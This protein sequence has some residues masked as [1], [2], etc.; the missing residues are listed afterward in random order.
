KELVGKK[1]K[2]L[3]DYF[4]NGRE[5]GDNGNG[6]QV[7]SGDFVNTEEGTGIVHI[8]PAFGE[9]DMELGKKYGLPFIQHVDKNGRFADCVTEW[10]GREVKPK[11]DPQATEREIIDALRKKGM[12]FREE[13]YTHNY[14]H[15][16]RCDTPLLNYA[17]DSWFVEVTKFKE[18][19][20]DNNK[21]IHWVPAHIKEG[22]FGKW[23]EQA[24]DWAISR[25]RYWG[26]PL[27]V[28]E[29][30][31]CGKRTVIG[32]R[33]E[34]EEASGQTVSDLHKHLVDELTWKCSACGG[35]M[36]RIS[37]VLDCWFES[38]SMPYAQQHYPFEEKEKFEKNFPADFVAEGID[39]TR[40]WF[41][42]LMVLSSALFGR[43]T[44]QNVIAN[45]IV[46]AE[47]GQKMSKSKQNYPD[48]EEVFDKYG[49]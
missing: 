49:V 5:A 42:T 29:C 31:A 9:D 48:P 20:V 12:V 30:R 32:S 45:G 38:G 14:P 24:K 22:R 36:K 26:T 40:G 11:E 6:W 16:W 23:L 28:W 37:E 41:Y 3:F 17:A 35:E 2:P 25:N 33:K 47:D 27:P 13:N 39:Q 46:L 44:F 4:I 43:E 19:L 7:Y 34:L 1:Y 15:C 10:A 21:N 18:N 8:A